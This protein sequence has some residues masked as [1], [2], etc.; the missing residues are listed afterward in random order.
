MNETARNWEQLDPSKLEVQPLLPSFA[1]FSKELFHRASEEFFLTKSNNDL[2]QV[3]QFCYENAA[4]AIGD[5]F[6]TKISINDSGNVFCVATKDRPFIVDSIAELLKERASVDIFL[7]PIFQTKTGNLSVS[8]VELSNKP[9]MDLKQELLSTLSDLTIVTDSFEQVSERLTDLAKSL[10]QDGKEELGRLAGW[11]R[12]GGFVFL[13]YECWNSDESSP[14]ISLGLAGSLSTK[15]EA[16]ICFNNRSEFCLTTKV[17]KSSVKRRERIKVACFREGNEKAHC[18]I[19]LFSSEA[20]KQP[21]AEVPLVRKKLEHIIEQEQLIH[22]SHDYKET[23]SVIDG[24]PKAELFILNSDELL[25]N[26]R[27]I[28]SLQQKKRTL[29]T[30]HTDALKAVTYALVIIP[31]ERFSEEVAG[32]VKSTLE[33]YFNVPPESSESYYAISDKLRIRQHVILPTSAGSSLESDAIE[34]LTEEVSKVTFSWEDEL[35]LVAADFFDPIKLRSIAKKLPGRYKALHSPKEVTRDLRNLSKLTLEDNVSLDLQ[36]LENGEYNLTVYKVGERLTLSSVIP[37]LENLG[38]QV[39]YQAET[40][41]QLERLSFV[42]DFRLLFPKTIKPSEPL[43]EGMLKVLKK[44][45]ENTPINSLLVEP[46]LSWKEVCL[47]HTAVQYALQLRVYTSFRV[48]SNALA[49]NPKVTRL[50]VDYF[51]IK[52]DPEQNSSA[53]QVTESWKQLDSELNKVKRLIDDRVLRTLA[54]IFSA[55]VRTNYFI[56]DVGGR[57]SLKLDCSQ[58]QQMPDP[59]PKYEIFVASP[60]FAGVHL[61]SSKVARGGLRW[62]ERPEDF[63]TEVLGLMKTQI[64][65]NSVIIPSGAKG[66]FVLKPYAL[67]KFDSREAVENYYKDFIRSLLE[68]SDNLVSGEEVVTP[69]QVLR[70]DEKDHYLVVAADK[71]TATFSDL[72]NEIAT[73]EFNFWLGDAFASGGSKGYDH[74]KLGITARGAWVATCRHLREL[75]IDIEKQPISTIGIGDMGG[76]VFG[77]GLLSSPNLQLVGAFNHMHIFIDPSPNLDAAFKE[78]QRLFELPRSTWTDYNTDLI[79]SGGGIFERTEKSIPIS[80]KAAKVLGCKPGNYSGEEVI[81]SILRAPV[82]LFWNGGIGTYVKH[83]DQTHL[84]VGD[85]ANDN[86]RVNADKL[87]V[88]IVGEGGNLGLTQEARIQFASLGGRINTDAVDNSAGVHLSDTEV[89][90]KILLSGNS[91]RDKLLEEHS[92]ISCDTVLLRNYYQTSSI[93]LDCLRSA[94]SLAPFSSLL[95][96]VKKKYPVIFS[97]EI[98]PDER[99]VESRAVEKR[100]LYRPEVA[101]LISIAKLDLKEKVLKSELTESSLIKEYSKKYFPKTI[102]ES[103]SHPLNKEIA[104]T[105]FSNSLVD[106][107]GSTFISKI[108]DDIGC[109]E[110]E[111]SGAYICAYNSL[112]A[113]NL[114]QQFLALDTA[115]LSKTFCK[116]NIA[117][118]GAIESTTRWFLINVES[119]KFEFELDEVYSHYVPEAAKLL[120]NVESYLPKSETRLIEKLTKRLQAG[121]VIDNVAKQVSNLVHANSILVIIRLSQDCKESPKQVAELYFQ[122]SHLLKITSLNSLSEKAAPKTRWEEISLISIQDEISRSLSKLI[123]R[124]LTDGSG[125]VDAFMKSHKRKVE[126]YQNTLE[127]AAEGEVD[128]TALSVLANHL[129]R[130]TSSN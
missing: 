35:E 86:V 124:I 31:R 95:G 112:G 51:I 47:V 54:N 85:R 4:S 38:F 80:E 16:K 23:V 29:L 62:S 81:Q 15:A 92:S 89:N 11:L 20:T 12:D 41:L 13:G 96:K 56:E 30:V 116:L 122:A 100:P 83:S 33:T 108:Q 107:V 42:S 84:D 119:S 64:I 44:E 21:A 46:G 26:L 70:R 109:T 74:K 76:D 87:R 48:I 65:K 123:K 61:R 114:Y 104:A 17:E 18:L 9:E 28:L 99:E 5:N 91:N 7:H 39:L 52:F 90:F 43:I 113:K 45:L 78:R 32:E 79:S 126:N 102:G 82:D 73:T 49:N 125:S 103:C 111:V 110:A 37:L 117:L 2:T 63:R 66:G 98:L 121:G 106:L 75:G 55:C 93:T 105:E 69:K 128:I 127:A 57:I 25:D 10:V 67:E 14:H 8:Y 36:A 58:V 24:F 19:G 40:K 130:L 60:F 6:E 72:A 101:T 1:D 3:A 59:R 68:I 97:G 34:S 50:L 22:H 118:S 77:N 53:S 115:K 129:R 88:K 71:G 120:S 94:Q 27:L